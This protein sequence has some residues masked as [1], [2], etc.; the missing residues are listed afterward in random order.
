MRDQEIEGSISTVSDNE[1]NKDSS[2]GGIKHQIFAELLLN[3]GGLSEHQLKRVKDNPILSKEPLE[4]LR[5]APTKIENLVISSS[6][7]QK[8]GSDLESVGVFVRQQ[9][10]GLKLDLREWLGKTGVIAPV[11]KEGLIEGLR[12]YRSVNDEKP[13]QLNKSSNDEQ[14]Q[15]ETSESNK[16]QTD[17]LVNLVSDLRLFHSPNEDCFVTLPID[18]H[19]ENHNIDHKKFRS[20]LSMKFYES[21]G[22]T[23]NKQAVADLIEHLRGKALFEG[24][25]VETYVRV[26]E[27]GGE[28]IIDLCNE[29]WEVVKV[30]KTGWDVASAD[31]VEVKF[32]RT[33]GMKSL[34]TPIRGGSLDELKKFVNVT[35]KH[36][37]LVAAWVINSFRPNKPFPILVL[38]GE[39]GSAKTTTSEVLRSLLDPNTV[40][41]RSIPRSERDLAI[42][43]NNSWLILM[44]NLSGLTSEFSDSLCRLATGG[45][46]STRKLYSDADEA[47][48]NIMRPVLINGID[49]LATR[50]DLLDRSLVITCQNIPE[51]KRRTRSKFDLEFE[52]ARGRIFGAML[53]RLSKGLR[54]LQK[55]QMMRLPRMAD[56]A[57]FGASIFGAEFMDR[58]RELRN[59]SNDAALESS[60]IGELMLRFMEK[61][62]K[63]VGTATQLLHELKNMAEWEVK[64]S[65]YFP[66]HANMMSNA[67]N[68]IA[69]N[70]RVKGIEIDRGTGRERRN[71]IIEKVDLESAQSAQSALGNVIHTKEVTTETD[72]I[73][74]NQNEIGTLETKIDTFQVNDDSMPVFEQ[75]GVIN[76]FNKIQAGNNGDD[77]DDHHL[78]KA[79]EQKE[80]AES[81][82]EDEVPF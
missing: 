28:I 1:D 17:I 64:N 46:L 79:D 58:Y 82:Y 59:E 52:E 29:N 65:T 19:N 69:P 11:F 74:D 70:L 78:T 68:R 8:F 36:F 80:L 72:A 2:G 76:R 30:S 16:K 44:D 12:I 25:C 22:K 27:N 49:E 39:H 23:P 21:E 37:V 31:D 9:D 32:R 40:P 57:M 7:S 24:R 48:F 63:W 26:A 47:L 45:G 6:I 13:F 33:P 34:P 51:T 14:N 53:D 10:G 67:L 55:V 43:A 15:K 56:F 50:P 60:P 75:I 77:S 54:D 41:V 38:H 18:S 35:N 73:G 4:W 71:F 3:L 20:W 5:T 62:N 42:S 81:E 61:N 66:K